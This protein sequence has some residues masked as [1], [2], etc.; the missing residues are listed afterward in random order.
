MCLAISELL[1]K[2]TLS[3]QETGNN[4]GIFS[5]V[6]NT[7]FSDLAGISESGSMNVAAGDKVFATY[8]DPQNLE[9]ISGT[10]S[11]VATATAK[12]GRDGILTLT[13]S[14]FIVGSDVTIE[15][16]DA[17]QNAAAGAAEKVSVTVTNTRTNELQAIELT[18]TGP[19]TGIF[20]EK[21]GTTDQTTSG[22]I[23]AKGGDELTAAYVDTVT[24]S[25]T[26]TTRTA[27]T[28]AINPIWAF[29]VSASVNPTNLDAPGL[30]DL[31]NQRSQQRQHD[32]YRPLSGRTSQRKMA[33]Y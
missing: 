3:I 9:N 25:G 8:R 15:V 18:E 4:T 17:D 10:I 14:S 7:A 21:L 13:P 32:A 19:N 26:E 30:T 24:S 23:T 5:G 27:S 12:D 1:K 11:V 28:T 29:T 33:A 16:A 22:K 6:L 31:R 2:E 20:R